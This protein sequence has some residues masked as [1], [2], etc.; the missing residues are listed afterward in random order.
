M[1]IFW[2]LS[3]DDDILA[4]GLHMKAGK[5]FERY[6]LLVERLFR[7]GK[8]KII[9]ATNQLAYGVNLPAKSCVFSGYNKFLS[10]QLMQQA[11]ELSWPILL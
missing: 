9:F 4:A 8:L 11:G 5:R 2:L 3:W 6:T 1:T 10:P 7:T